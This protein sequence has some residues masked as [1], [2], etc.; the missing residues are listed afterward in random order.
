LDVIY[1][2]KHPELETCYRAKL[3]S[4]GTEEA[5]AHF[6]DYGDSASVP[7]SDIHTCP[8]SVRDTPP[9]AMKCGLKLNVPDDYQW[10]PGSV[11]VLKAVAEEGKILEAVFCGEVDGVQ[12]IRLLKAEEHNFVETIEEAIQNSASK[13][14]E[15]EVDPLSDAVDQEIEPVPE[16]LE[17]SAEN[18]QLVDEPN[19]E[20]GADTDAGDVITEHVPEVNV[21]LHSDA[22]EGTEI[23]SAVG[24]AEP[25]EHSSFDHSIGT[26]SGLAE[27]AGNDYSDGTSRRNSVAEKIAIMESLINARSNSPTSPIPDVVVSSRVP[28]VT[29]MSVDSA[30]KCE[31][32]AST[33]PEKI[34]DTCEVLEEV[35]TVV[36]FSYEPEVENLVEVVPTT[37]THHEVVEHIEE[38]SCITETFGDFHPQSVP[39]ESHVSVY[40][41]HEMEGIPIEEIGPCCDVVMQEHIPNFVEEER[42]SEINVCT[43]EERLPYFEEIKNPAAAIMPEE[44]AVNPEEEPVLIVEPDTSE[45]FETSSGTGQVVGSFETEDNQVVPYHSIL[46]CWLML[47][48]NFN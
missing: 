15:A 31:P 44:V 2:V 29:A 43:T 38:E 23:V 16:G 42:I 4:I 14:Q 20:T 36:E 37:A 27:S 8:E 28:N 26:D 10:T 35:Q 25:E 48:L 7:L 13:R 19:E 39:V 45:D 3:T 41:S 30:K 40:Q 32:I 5:V 12:L 47:K 18:E 33:E 11:R 1:S 34:V 24:A 9:M 6:I 21:T 46:S 17:P 22:A